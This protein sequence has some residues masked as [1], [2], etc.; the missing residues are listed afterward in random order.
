MKS[1]FISFIKKIKYLKNFHLKLCFKMLKRK[2]L[3]LISF[4]LVS[5]IN[6]LFSGKCFKSSDDPCLL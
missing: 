1:G 4:P 5:K 3:K 2:I 6:E